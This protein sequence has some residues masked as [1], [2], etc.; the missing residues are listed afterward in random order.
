MGKLIKFRQDNRRGVYYLEQSSNFLRDALEQYNESRLNDA[1][2][3]IRM[4]H[5]YLMEATMH[6][7]VSHPE[8]AQ[9][10]E[11]LDQLSEQLK[12]HNIRP[13]DPPEF[14]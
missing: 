11:K 9:V 13:Y 12:M 3:S 2:D 7:G 10:S 14:Q 6:L 8:C 5:T 4:A 1:L